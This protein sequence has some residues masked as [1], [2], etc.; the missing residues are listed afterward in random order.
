MGL[1]T[2]ANLKSKLVERCANGQESEQ[3]A[4]GSFLVQLSDYIIIL[5][6]APSLSPNLYQSSH[7]IHHSLDKRGS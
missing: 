5:I 6:L 1:E 7:V 3:S 4:G 2:F